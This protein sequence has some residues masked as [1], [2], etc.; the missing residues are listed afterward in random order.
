MYILLVDF[1]FIKREIILGDPEL[2][3][4]KSFKS[5]LSPFLSQ[6]AKPEVGSAIIPCFPSIF[7]PDCCEWQAWA[8]PME[9]LPAHGL[10]F[11]A[12]C[13]VV[14]GLA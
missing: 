12:A 10:S 5:S 4:W 3:S 7:L 1:K 6:E 11:L 14:F 9:F 2:I 8:M 13:P